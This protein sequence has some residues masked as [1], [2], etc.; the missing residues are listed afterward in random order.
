MMFL[1]RFWWFWFI[2][3]IQLEIWTFTPV[4]LCKCVCVC[5]NEGIFN[6]AMME[7]LTSRELTYDA[8]R[9]SWSAVCVSLVLPPACVCLTSVYLMHFLRIYRAIWIIRL[10][11]HSWV[12]F[13]ASDDPIRLHI[14]RAEAAP[15]MTHLVPD[16]SPRRFGPIG[17]PMCHMMPLIDTHVW[18]PDYNPSLMLQ[19]HRLLRT[20]PPFGHWQ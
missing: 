7:N 12:K 15:D 9:L 17:I 8:F 19:P 3:R 1:L 16:G 11:S 2:S 18:L 13:A 14:D 10:W 4:C 6:D 20:S 5:V